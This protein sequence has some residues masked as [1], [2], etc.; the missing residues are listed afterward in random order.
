MRDEEVHVDLIAQHVAAI[1]VRVRLLAHGQA[2]GSAALDGQVEIC[3]AGEAAARDEGAGAG[4]EKYGDGGAYGTSANV[5]LDGS[6]GSVA[7][8][9]A[10]HR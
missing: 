9:S 6:G 7:G 3:A 4:G 1:L 10:S 5:S 8:S 2:D